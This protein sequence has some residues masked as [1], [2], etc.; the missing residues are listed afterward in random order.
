MRKIL[1]LC[2]LLLAG[3][4]SPG[5]P[6]AGTPAAGTPATS[7]SAT[8]ETT[9]APGKFDFYLLTLSWSPQF[10]LTHG[11][12]AECSLHLG[13]TVHGLWPQNNNGT[14]PENCNHQPGPTNPASWSD[15]MPDPHLVAH[16]WTTHG[17]CSGLAADA[18]FAQIRKAFHEVVIP[19]RLTVVPPGLSVPPATLLADFAQANPTFPKGSFA[20]SCSGGALTAAQACLSK[21]LQPIACPAVPSCKSTIVK[22]APRSTK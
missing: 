7:A 18:Y 6:A 1:L 5:T 17:T 21:T 3:C 11:Q 13:F 4:K 2:G 8:A 20:L 15:I 16:E 9:A 12:D 14:Y 19:P 22:V 10:C